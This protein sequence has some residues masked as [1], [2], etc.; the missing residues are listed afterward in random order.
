[1]NHLYFGDCLDILKDL[2]AQ[3]PNGFIDL[4]YVDPPFNS[5]R[6]YNILFEAIEQKDINAQKQAFAD[7]WSSVSYIDEKNELAEKNKD[8]YDFLDAL[9]RIRSFNK[10]GLSYLTIMAH[11]IYYMHAVL[12]DTGSFYL[13]CDPT[14]S[15]YLKLV[16]D[17]IFE[18]KNFRN[19]ISWK[20]SSPKSLNTK[21]FP[22]CRDIIFR[23]SKSEVYLFNKRFT[24]HDVKYLDKF[25]RF[26]DVDG[27][28]YRYD[29]LANPNKDRPNLEY[30][31]P[32]GSGTVRVW[33]WTKERMQ[34]AYDEGIVILPENGKVVVLKRYLDEQNGQPITNDWHDIEHLHG[35][36]KSGASKE[37]LGYPTQ[38]PTALLERIIESSSNEGDVVADFFCGCGT[39]VAAAENLNRKWLGVDI[40]HL[41][42]RLI[43]KRI[44]DSHGEEAFE[45]IRIHGFPRDVASAKMLAKETKGGSFNFQNWAIEVLL[46]G[47][48]NEKKT[49]DGGYDGYITFEMPD[50]KE[51]ILIETKSGNVT[52]GML[53]SFIQTLAAQ[54]A[55]MGFFVCFADQVTKGMREEALREGYFNESLFEKR[56]PKVQ[57][58]TIED[59]LESKRPRYPESL[60]TTFKSAERKTAT[61]NE[62]SLFDE[63]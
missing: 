39:T 52:I 28:R 23:Y 6:N 8:L 34:K 31:F 11:R 30:E 50:K 49:G 36:S 55:S 44:R 33:R 43:L 15:H 40:S 24:S 22:S 38:K 4:I 7:T 47:V 1:M 63:D 10:S 26:T 37:A 2:S 60:R 25:Y 13:H 57:L 42:V 35:T 17:I 32:E 3:H 56:Y 9:D 53:R 45:N 21:N 14:M 16:C 62:A 46:G 12:K 59:L 51:F 20:R 29:N 48:A 5:K 27:R 54:N 19:E 58:V 61:V 18:Q 41:A